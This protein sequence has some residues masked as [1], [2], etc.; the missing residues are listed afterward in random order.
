V[1]RTEPKTSTPNTQTADP[2]ITARDHQGPRRTHKRR[3]R[4]NMT[5]FGLI[6]PYTGLEDLSALQRP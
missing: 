3:H 4:I 5:V 1:V 2:A 6:P